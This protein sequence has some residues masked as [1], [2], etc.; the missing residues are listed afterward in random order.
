MTTQPLFSA[1]DQSAVIPVFGFAVTALPPSPTSA[2]RPAPSPTEPAPM[3]SS[4][5]PEQKLSMHGRS[6]E[7]AEY[8]SFSECTGVFEEDTSFWNLTK[9]GEYMELRFSPPNLGGVTLKLDLGLMAKGNA[10]YADNEYEVTLNGKPVPIQITRG[11]D[12][13]DHIT[14]DSLE[15]RLSTEEGL[16]K[17]N[18]IRIVFLEGGL[19]IVPTNV[20]LAPT[21]VI[22]M[23]FQWVQID[24]AFLAKGGRE[25]RSTSSTHGVTTTDSSTKRFAKKVGVAVTAKGKL[26]FES[27]SVKLSAAFTRS[28]SKTHSVAVT[29]KQT[30]TETFMTPVAPAPMCY[31]LWQLVILFKADGEGIEYRCP[32][33]VAGKVQRAFPL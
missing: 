28:S 22:T 17:D 2:D 13:G 21:I 30:I 11:E 9:P 3:A 32:S 18:A 27:L 25:K 15:A 14:N 1:S 16:A 5:I 33:N 26:F 7:G 6:P 24:S 4:G 8:L 29:D 10:H 23:E 19:P 31:Q 12:L 20:T